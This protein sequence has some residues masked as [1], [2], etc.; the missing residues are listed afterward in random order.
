MGEAHWSTA[1]EAH[2]WL[3]TRGRRVLEVQS[4]VGDVSPRHYCR[5][6][7]ADATEAIV[8]Y[9]PPPAREAL[10]RFVSTTGLLHAAAVRV[11]KILAIDE[12]QGWM[13]LEDL[14][15]QTLFDLGPDWPTL[16]PYFEDALDQLRRIQ[17]VSPDLVAGLNP[18]LDAALLRRELAQTQEA[19]LEPRFG[20]G[21]RD[22]QDALEALCVKLAS[23][24]V[25]V[26]HRDLMARNLVPLS[27][28]EDSPPRVGVLDH[29]D[30]RLGPRFYDL[31]S[32]LN[33]SLFAPSKLE[34]NWLDRHLATEDDHR[35]YRRAVAQRTLKALG[36]FARCAAEGS[37][38][39]E[40]LIAPTLERA[41][42]V[43][44]TLP[45]GESLAAKL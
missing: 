17:G 7:F 14:G 33:D 32:L 37:Q 1:R 35:A 41:R 10:G 15:K 40:A 2:S 6:L 19:F 20:L 9:Y 34:A 43:L 13:L 23:T 38:K 42:R 31:A 28:V 3:E 16:A 26:C 39:H 25:V 44:Q 45:E 5:A 12:Q 29:Q 24:G 4:V 21:V 36:T 30:L 8:A 22:T 27:T 11:P 18:P